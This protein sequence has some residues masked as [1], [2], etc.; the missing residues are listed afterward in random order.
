LIQRELDSLHKLCFVG[1]GTRRGAQNTHSDSRTPG[2]HPE[3]PRVQL[4]DEAWGDGW[5]DVPHT[6][7]PRWLKHAAVRDTVRDGGISI[8]LLQ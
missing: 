5:P 6:R 1:A 8:L 7:I 4:R 3:V 2:R